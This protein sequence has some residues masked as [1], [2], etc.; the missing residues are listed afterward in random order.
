M[1]TQYI[2]VLFSVDECYV[3]TN[4]YS[5]VLF[6]PGNQSK[7]KITKYII[8]QNIKKLTYSAQNKSHITI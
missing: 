8:M 2:S 5:G 4:H 7:H 3:N 6:R 1:S